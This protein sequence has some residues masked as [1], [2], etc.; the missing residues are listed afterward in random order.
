MF[1]LDT[2]HDW[3][4]NLE[5]EFADYAKE[6]GSMRLALNCAL[7]AYHLHEKVWSE[8]LKNDAATRRALGIGKDRKEFLAWIGR[9]CV[10]FFWIRELATAAKHG[11]ETS[12]EARLVSLLPEARNLPNAGAEESHWNGPMPY[13]TAG[14]DVL[15]IDNGPEAGEVHNRYMPVSYLLNAVL[16]FWRQFFERYGPT[17]SKFST[18]AEAVP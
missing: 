13:L 12:F 3:L 4:A 7:A 10:W 11:R 16:C 17:P 14:Q 9:H 6:P 18:S 1:G 15:L 5:A 8:W 2:P